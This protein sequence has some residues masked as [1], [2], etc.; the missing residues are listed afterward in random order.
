MCKFLKSKLK[1]TTLQNRQEIH[2]QELE[3]KIYRYL[4]IEKA[5]N[6]HKSIL[7]VSD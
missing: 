2:K 3:K 4:Q 7:G 5:Q 1:K 6:S